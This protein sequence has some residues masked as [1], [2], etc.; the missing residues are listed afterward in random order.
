MQNR[1]IEESVSF[2]DRW[3]ESVRQKHAT[4]VKIL[5]NEKHWEG[6]DDLV[7]TEEIQT[8]IAAQ[9]A[10]MLVGVEN[11][12]FDALHTLLIF[13]ENYEREIQDGLVRSEQSL[14][15]EA[16]QDGRISLSWAQVQH[17]FMY[18]EDGH[19]VVIHEF[20]HH[21]DAVSGSMDGRPV[22]SQNSDQRLWNQVSQ[23]E[24]QQLVHEVQSMKPTLLDSYGATNEAEFFA[25]ASEFFFE[26]PD[27]LSREHALLY[28]L[29]VKLYCVDP[30]EWI[31]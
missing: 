17:G 25:V 13:P 24:Y 9:A 23:R 14:A 16:W 3:P 27:L 5:I 26:L 19:N 8:A 4:A 15:G 30:R 12:Y 28:D 6:C 2:F 10:I 18:P 29:L 21:I 31:G 22:L 1:V 20:A 7:L 11:Y